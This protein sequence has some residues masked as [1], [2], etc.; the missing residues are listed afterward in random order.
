MGR[1]SARQKIHTQC[2]EY[3]MSSHDL[4]LSSINKTAPVKTDTKTA[5]VEKTESEGFVEELKEVMGLKEKDD[6]KKTAVEEKGDVE[7]GEAAEKSKESESVETKEE[8]TAPSPN[9]IL[10]SAGYW[11]PIDPNKITVSR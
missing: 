2:R 10:V 7:K 9:H 1:Y 3:T 5:A 4:S 11:P 6:A 8:T